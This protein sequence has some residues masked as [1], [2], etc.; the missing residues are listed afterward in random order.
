MGA[1]CGALPRRHRDGPRI[2]KVLLVPAST[3]EKAAA[4]AG[5]AAVMVDASRS[6]LAACILRVDAVLGVPQ[7]YQ[8]HALPSHA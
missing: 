2:S 3:S 6:P 7:C 1:G 4:A 8:I 5:A